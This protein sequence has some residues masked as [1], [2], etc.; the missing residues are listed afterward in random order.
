MIVDGEKETMI[1]YMDG[2]G[3]KSVNIGNI[4]SVADANPINFGGGYT[5]AIDDVAIFRG[6]WIRTI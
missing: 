4:G 3:A 6:V 5:G 1:S 2:K